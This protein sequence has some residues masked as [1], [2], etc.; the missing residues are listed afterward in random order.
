[1]VKKGLW[2]IVLLAFLGTARCY[3][4]DMA[5]ALGGVPII[6]PMVQ[7]PQPTPAYVKAIGTPA[8]STLPGTDLATWFPADAQADPYDAKRWSAIDQYVTTAGTK[9]GWTEVCK[10]VTGAAGTDRA[11]NPK[12]GALACSSDPTVTQFQQFAAELLG[13]QAAVALWIKGELNGSTAAVISRQAQLRVTCTTGV[14]ARQG[15]PETAWSQACA[16]AMDAAYLGGDGPTTFTA[17]GEAYTLAAAEIAKM[18]AE[19]D[20]EPGFF[21]PAAAAPKP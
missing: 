12:L 1:V 20:Q 5:S 7:P 8:A 4:A 14:I 17:L 18:D 2:A 3:N 9:T 21:G 10:K 19:I 11:A 15:A 13:A 6:G 16:K